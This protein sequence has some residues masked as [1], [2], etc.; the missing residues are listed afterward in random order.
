MPET[1]HSR[2]ISLI[3]NFYAGATLSDSDLTEL[4]R[5]HSANVLRVN[6]ITTEGVTK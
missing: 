1:D 4:T 6:S 5:L 3:R 2:Y